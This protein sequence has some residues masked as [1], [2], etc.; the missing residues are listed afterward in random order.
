MMTRMVARMRAQ[1]SAGDLSHGMLFLRVAEGDLIREFLAATSAVFARGEPSDFAGL[2]LE[3][4]GGRAANHEFATSDVAFDK[5]CTDAA[6]RGV[7]GVER[8]GKDKFIGAMMDAFTRS[9]MDARATAELLPHAKS[10]LNA[11]LQVLYMKLDELLT[12]A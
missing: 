5:L 1:L 7:L 8:Y 2:S 12:R 3:P 9:R 10:A 6:M 4:E 11:E